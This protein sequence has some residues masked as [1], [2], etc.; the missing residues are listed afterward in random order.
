MGCDTEQRVHARD[1]KFKTDGLGDVVPRHHAL[2]RDS[3][4]V[5]I[6]CR[7]ENDRHGLTLV[8]QFHA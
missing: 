2:R 7:Y 1:Q 3:I 6:A 5:A 8:S 4:D